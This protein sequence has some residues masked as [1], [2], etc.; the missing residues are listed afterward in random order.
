LP[1]VG[2]E[3]AIGGGVSLVLPPALAAGMGRFPRPRFADRAID[4]GGWPTC[5]P[6]ALANTLAEAAAA[7]SP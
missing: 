1:G 7:V 2:V 4:D 6:R 5:W 3:P